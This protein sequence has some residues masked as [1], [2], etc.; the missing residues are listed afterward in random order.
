MYVLV[1][2][3]K[4]ELQLDQRLCTIL[5]VMSLTCF[6]KAP[7]QQV[8]TNPNDQGTTNDHPNPM[9]IFNL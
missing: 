7:I 6:E 5:H 8:L 1:A 9:L 3:F 2:I 4:K